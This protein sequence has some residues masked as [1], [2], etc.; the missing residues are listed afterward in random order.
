MICGRDGFTRDFGFGRYENLSGAISWL[1]FFSGEGEAKS[2]H[3][4]P[5]WA[6]GNL[7]RA[8]HFT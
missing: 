4:K 5:R 2:L 1:T 7:Q 3:A 8:I 6:R